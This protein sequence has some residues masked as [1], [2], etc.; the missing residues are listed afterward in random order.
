M[1][2]LYQIL[3]EIE[4]RKA[5]GAPP[6]GPEAVR[7]SRPS[8]RLL[9]LTGLVALSALIAL[10]S[11]WIFKRAFYP[12][13]ARFT[14][15]T[16]TPPVYR[17]SETSPP[18]TRTPPPAAG[19]SREIRSGRNEDHAGPTTSPRSSS[20]LPERVVLLKPEKVEVQPSSPKKPS[21]G[22]P[23]TPIKKRAAG[24]PPLS[25]EERLRGLLVRAE[26]LREK[27]LC[28]EALPLYEKYLEVRK[29]VGVLNNYAA[30]LWLEGRLVEAEEAFREALRLREDPL[31]RLNLVLLALQR[32][33]TSG[34]C[35]EYVR[36]KGK[37]LEASAFKLYYSVRDF[38]QNNCPSR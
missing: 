10:G 38:L 35:Q 2:K 28:G 32:G 19:P 5:K 3:Q 27:G 31:V 18:E 29:E 37:N 13:P 26:A 7:S 15:K 23:E 4:G 1:S 21:F 30:C 24:F 17:E 16:G 20:A 8:S 36:I 12:S 33:D 22:E 11:F 9:I 34:A 6:V 14:S 25:P